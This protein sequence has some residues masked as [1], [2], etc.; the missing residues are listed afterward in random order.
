MSSRHAGRH[1]LLLV[2]SPENIQIVIP[3]TD[4]FCRSW[5]SPRQIEG[6]GMKKIALIFAL[7]FA[8]TTGMAVVTVVAHTDQAMAD[9]T[10]TNC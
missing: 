5:H 8:L 2:A 1:A 9:C 3:I 10:G 6:L 4:G 7:A